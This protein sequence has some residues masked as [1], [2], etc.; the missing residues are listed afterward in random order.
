MWKY[1]GDEE[2]SAAGMHHT[3]GLALCARPLRLLSSNAIRKTSN[4]CY[5]SHQF[6]HHSSIG[7]VRAYLYRYPV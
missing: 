2:R 1:Y 3:S 5:T 7:H 6:H 4:L